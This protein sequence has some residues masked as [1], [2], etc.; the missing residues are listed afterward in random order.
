VIDVTLLELGRCYT[1]HS[2][3]KEAH[4]ERVEAGD[5]QDSHNTTADESA[6]RPLRNV[7]NASLQRLSGTDARIPRRK[8]EQAE[9]I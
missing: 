1:V 2:D 9:A 7:Q 6:P 5:F 8:P 4:Q 3:Q